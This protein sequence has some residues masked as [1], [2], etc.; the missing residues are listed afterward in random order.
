MILTVPP[1]WISLQEGFL[2]PRWS[3][4]NFSRKVVRAITGMW[5][6]TTSKKRDAQSF[7]AIKS[8]AADEF[9]GV[10]LLNPVASPGVRKLKGFLLLR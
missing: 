8:S 2:V 6:F 4:C 9:S 1:A 3:P 7:A 5:L 10:A